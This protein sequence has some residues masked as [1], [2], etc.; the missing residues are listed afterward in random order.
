MK[1]SKSVALIAIILI[2][3]AACG[4]SALKRHSYAAQTLD[5]LAGVARRE[6]LALREKTLREAGER[7]L[8]AG[9]TDIRSSVE[10]AATEFQPKIDAVN[11]FVSAKNIYIRAV[12]LVA[13]QEEP[14][15]DDLVIVLRNAIDVYEGVRAALGSTI[16]PIP[17]IV[18]ELIR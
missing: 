12:L 6:S 1:P 18:K 15:F 13:Q 7:A 8:A 5:D 14:G 10:L 16:P 11:A 3:L 17:P 4:D 2:L 9:S